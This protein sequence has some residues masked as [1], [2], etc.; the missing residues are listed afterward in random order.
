MIAERLGDRAVA[1]AGEA[2]ALQPR[3]EVE[4]RSAAAA[5]RQAVEL[6]EPHRKQPGLADPELIAEPMRAALDRLARLGG[7]MTPDDVIGKVF[8]TFCVGK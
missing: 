3:H 4:L 7:A 8:A 5:I 6:T 1:L 2:M